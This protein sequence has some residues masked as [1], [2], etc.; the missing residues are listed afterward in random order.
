MTPTVT[1]L[2]SPTA[3]NAVG[4]TV[5]VGDSLQPTTTTTTRRFVRHVSTTTTAVEEIVPVFTEVT[6]PTTTSA[7]PTTT[8]VFALNSAFL[9]QYEAPTITA[10]A[11]AEFLR[12][13]V[14]YEASTRTAVARAELVRAH[15]IAPQEAESSGGNL[16][17]VLFVIIG[18]LVMGAV[19]F[20]GLGEHHLRNRVLSRA[21]R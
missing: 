6:E 15:A 2:G 3:T 11:H 5:P 13:N 4:V 18:V 7:A 12:S 9:Q 17:F 8:F 10:V 14:S 16:Q 19:V 1:T 20:I 21:K